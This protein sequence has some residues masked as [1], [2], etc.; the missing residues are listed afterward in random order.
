M[1]ANEY[2]KILVF[3]TF[4]LDYNYSD[5]DEQYWGSISDQLYGKLFNFFLLILIEMFRCKA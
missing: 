4:S 3:Y 5:F 1:K 2:F